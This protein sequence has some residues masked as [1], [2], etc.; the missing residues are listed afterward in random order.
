[1][2]LPITSFQKL[3]R[4]H[5][6]GQD[7]WHVLPHQVDAAVE[8]ILDAIE[9]FPCVERQ[10]RCN[11]QYR[12]VRMDRPGP[13]RNLLCGCVLLEDA[14]KPYYYDK[15]HL[16]LFYTPEQHLHVNLAGQQSQPISSIDEMVALVQAYQ[17]RVAHHQ[18][19]LIKRQKQQDLKVQAILAQVR[20]MAKE[21]QFDFA[22]SVDKVK[23]TLYVRLSDE[24][25]F[26]VLVPFK[27]FKEVLPKLR[28]AIAALRDTYNTGVRFK[29][30]VKNADRTQWIRHQDL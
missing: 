20:K 27:E 29:T 19:R 1:M 18:A 12:F 4:D 10:A 23:L 7:P 5:I 28:T 9:P 11:Q 14:T 3:L 2:T 25:Y 26:A 17:D 21:D 24:D 8:R 15:T 16:H 22:T 30:R 13:P 6:T